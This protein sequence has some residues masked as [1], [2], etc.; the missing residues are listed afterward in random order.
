M[1]G[2]S[3]RRFLSGG[4]EIEKLEQYKAQLQR[5]IQGVEARIEELREG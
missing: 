5:E 2:C 3:F 4:E 1:C